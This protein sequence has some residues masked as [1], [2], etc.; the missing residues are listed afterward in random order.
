MLANPQPG[1]TGV[2]T[3][4]GRVTLVAFGNGNTLYSTYT[5]WIVT[6]TDSTGTP[7]TGGSLSLVSDPAGPHPYPSDFYYASN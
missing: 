3:T 4:L 2:T 7:W 5:Q 1:Q 6:L